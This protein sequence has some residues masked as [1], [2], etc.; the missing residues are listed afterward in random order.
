M[1]N[2][3]SAPQ[4]SNK[5]WIILGIIVVVLAL[6]AIVFRTKLFGLKKPVVY[7]AVFLDNGQVYFGNLN[8]NILTNVYY[9]VGNASGTPAL[10]KL[11][12]EVYSPT[13]EIDF[14]SS[15]ILYTETLQSSSA[16]IKAMK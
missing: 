6:L 5:S 12:G 4:K 15:H 13:N 2:E 10:I 1:E 3:L 16:I 14:K 11:G 7:S 9:I 8:N